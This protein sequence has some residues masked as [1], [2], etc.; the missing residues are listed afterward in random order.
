MDKNI[1]K[2]LLQEAGK[3]YL[4]QDSQMNNVSNRVSELANEMS[5]LSK[6]NE[7]NYNDL[8]KL[9]NEAKN[10]INNDNMTITNSTHEEYIIGKKLVE[11]FSKHNIEVPKS[12]V[13]PSFEELETIEVNS[14]ISWDQYLENINMY[15]DKNGIDMTIDP[16]DELLTAEGKRI[17]KDRIKNDYSMKKANCDKYDYMIAA[18]CGV[19]AGIIDSFFVGMPGKSKLGNWTDMQT[20]K[21]VIKIA[22]MSGYKPSKDDEN[23]TANAIAFF[24]RRY[25]VNYDQATG[26]AAANLLGMKMSNHH[27]KSLGH[28][29]DLIGLLFSILDQFSSTSHFLDN[30]KL[31]TFDT[32]T[33]TL[34]GKNFIAKLFCGFSNWIGHL[35]SDIAGSSKGRRNNPNSR[36]SGIP[37]PLFELFQLCGKGSLKVYGNNDKANNFTQM[38]L[39]DLS[40]KIFEEGYDTR[41]AMA[42]AIPVV[43]NEILIKLIWAIKERFYENKA[44]KMCIP[45]GNNP[46][47]RKMLLT[48]HGVLCLLDGLDAAIQ[49]YGQVLLFALSLNFLAWK[50]LAFSGLIEVRA[51]YKENTIDLG[52]LE[53]DLEIEWNKLYESSEIKL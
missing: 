50:R 36:G 1:N 34:R 53:K 21:W 5:S 31:I 19:V 42:Q 46:E 16:F 52:A 27:I 12:I 23:N 9:L 39:A 32:K 22:K 3:A 33:Y 44:L 17:I 37:M 13:V 8:D 38:S 15:A 24:E 25:K 6:I 43:I 47:L 26:K 40:V 45:R 35:I 10:L 30:G 7:N 51:I 20:D 18:F 48:G 49:S 14:D 2:K 11:R 41:F 28:A 29:P 4:V